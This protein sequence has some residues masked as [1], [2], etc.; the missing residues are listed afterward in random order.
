MAPQGDA[1]QAY[2]IRPLGHELQAAS[3]NASTTSFDS[4]ALKSI[5]LR[6][7]GSVTPVVSKGLV[8]RSSQVVSPTDLKKLGIRVRPA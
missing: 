4:V 3:S 7:L 5:N 1:L 6:D 8:F 2:G